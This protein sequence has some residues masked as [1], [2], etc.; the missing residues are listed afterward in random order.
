[1][2]PVAALVLVVVTDFEF[3]LAEALVVNTFSTVQIQRLF[4]NNMKPPQFVD[5]YDLH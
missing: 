4:I 3:V 5:L 2:L 1:M